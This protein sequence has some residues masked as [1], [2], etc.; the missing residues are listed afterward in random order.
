MALSY[1]TT[2]RNNQ[3]DEITPLIDAGSGA[4]KVRIYSG[5]VPANVGAGLGGATLLA[6]L[7][8]TDPSAGAASGGVLTFSAIADDTSADA[9]GTAS[10]ARFLDSDNNAVIQG[11]VGT[12]GADINF[13]PSVAFVAGGLIEITSFTITAG[14]A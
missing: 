14:N 5:S 9:S 7:A 2:L 13:T 3:L 4:G 12:S 11:T 10:F 6:E 8:L 1:T